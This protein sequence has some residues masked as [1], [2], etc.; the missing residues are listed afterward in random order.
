MELAKIGNGDNKRADELVILNRAE[1]QFYLIKQPTFVSVLRYLVAH[2]VYIL[3]MTIGSDK[4]IMIDYKKI[5]NPQFLPAHI[6]SMRVY[7]NL[8]MLRY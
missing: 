6:T 8:R 7:L 2:G 3:G 4:L 5:Y 1:D